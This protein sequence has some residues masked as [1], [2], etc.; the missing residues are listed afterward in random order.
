LPPS[1]GTVRIQPPRRGDEDARP[2]RWRDCGNHRRRST[3]EAGHSDALTCI[4]SGCCPPERYELRAR[5]EISPGH[6]VRLG[7]LRS[8][9]RRMS[10]IALLL[11]VGAGHVAVVLPVRQAASIYQVVCWTREDMVTPERYPEADRLICGD[12]A[13]TRICSP[14]RRRHTR[15]HRDPCHQLD[16][17]LCLSVIDSSRRLHR[18]DVGAPQT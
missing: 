10:Q 17:T 5:Q 3:G 14:S 8:F 13:H 1:L 16:Q 4:A 11:I 18:D 15:G 2:G 6:F 9:W 7:R 12:P